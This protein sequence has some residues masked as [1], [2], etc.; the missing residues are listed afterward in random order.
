[1]ALSDARIIDL[2]KIV[3]RRGNLT[4]IQHGGQVPFDLE[5]VYYLCD[6]PGGAERGGHAHVKLEQFIVAGVLAHVQSN[7]AE[8]RA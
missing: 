7:A 1:M 4:F 6:V 3:D 8:S 5:R 2:P